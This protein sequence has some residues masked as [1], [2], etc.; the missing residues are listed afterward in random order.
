MLKTCLHIQL[1]DFNTHINDFI[2]YCIK[3]QNINIHT[4]NALLNENLEPHVKMVT[5]CVTTS[6]RV[7]L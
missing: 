6:L 1:L 4:Q 5:V 2:K 3:N 7:N